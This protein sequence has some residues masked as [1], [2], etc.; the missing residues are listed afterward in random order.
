MHADHASR[1]E[2]GQKNLFAEIDYLMMDFS[3]VGKKLL[4]NVGKLELDID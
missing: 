4:E 2:E 3:V 1:S